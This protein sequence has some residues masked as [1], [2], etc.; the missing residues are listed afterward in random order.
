METN[1]FEVFTRLMGGEDNLPPRLP[2]PPQA[3]SASIDAS[4]TTGHEDETSAPKKLTDAFGN[5]HVRDLDDYL[6][7]TAFPVPSAPAYDNRHNRQSNAPVRNPDKQVNLTLDPRKGEPSDLG[8]S[9]C[10][11]V[12][13]S[14]FPYK[15]VE[16]TFLQQIATVFFDQNKLFDRD[17]DM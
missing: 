11:F 10:T 8:M 5:L 3:S 6:G 7:T 9:F 13:F 12:A 14:K 15:Y 1:R 17:W 2:T 16:Q 4:T